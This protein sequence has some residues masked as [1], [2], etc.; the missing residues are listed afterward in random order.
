[1]TGLL[2][3]ATHVYPV[4]HDCNALC[5]LETALDRSLPE[6]FEELHGPAPRRETVMAYMAAILVDET[7]RGADEVLAIIRDIGGFGVLAGVFENPAI[8]HLEIH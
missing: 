6:I 4:R 8:A 1:M 3:G 2:L 5:R 7:Q